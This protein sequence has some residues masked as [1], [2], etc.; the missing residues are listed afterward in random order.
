[1]HN[2]LDPFAWPDGVLQI[3][4]SS[5]TIQSQQDDRLL[6]NLE[7]VGVLQDGRLA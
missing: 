2:E 3:E 4:Y 6:L 1:M 7:E 5:V